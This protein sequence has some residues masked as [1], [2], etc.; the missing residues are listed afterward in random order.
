MV[1]LMLQNFTVLKVSELTFCSFNIYIYHDQWKLHK[2]MEKNGCPTETQHK[3]II[4]TTLTL[5]LHAN[6]LVMVTKSY[7]KMH[8]IKQQDPQTE[9][10][11]KKI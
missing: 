9:G 11:L 2:I 4:F 1:N 6:I 5:T 7:V 3:K 10:S 8:S